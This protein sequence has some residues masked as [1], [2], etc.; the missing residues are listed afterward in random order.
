[1]SLRGWSRI[2]IAVRPGN[3]NSPGDDNRQMSGLPSP[4]RRRLLIVDD[5]PGLL[6]AMTTAFERAGRDVVGCRTF[7]EARQKL[8]AEDFQCLITDVRLGAFNGIQLAVIARDRNPDLAII[9]FSGFDD[10]V[11]REEAS[12]V[13]AS[14]LV[15]PVTVERLLQLVDAS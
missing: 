6:D 1:M 9:I 11:L 12:H 8:L 10:P 15:K 5:E 3:H 4:Q 2:P 13:G 14:Y 7:E